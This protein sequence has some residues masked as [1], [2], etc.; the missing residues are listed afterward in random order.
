MVIYINYYYNKCGSL[1]EGF[2]ENE[3]KKLGKEPPE[4]EDYP[5]APA[6]KELLEMEVN[7]FTS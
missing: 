7:G 4:S 6:P 2:F 3:L 1:F 5:L